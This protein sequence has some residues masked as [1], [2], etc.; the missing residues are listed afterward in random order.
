MCLSDS[1]W[2][3]ISEDDIILRIID[4]CILLRFPICKQ[5]FDMNLLQKVKAQIKVW[6]SLQRTANLNPHSQLALRLKSCMRTRESLF[7]K[8]DWSYY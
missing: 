1:I 7:S 8:S 5:V 3:Q 6:I 4:S 2:G